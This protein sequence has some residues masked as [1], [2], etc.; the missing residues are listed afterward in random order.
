M[1]HFSDSSQSENETPT[2]E[3]IHL[4]SWLKIIYIL[5]G[6]SLYIRVL[7]Y[8]RGYGQCVTSLQNTQFPRY[9][10]NLIKR[11]KD[12]LK[13]SLMTF[14]I[15]KESWE[16]RAAELLKEPSE[17][18]IC[19]VFVN[20]CKPV[21]QCVPVNQATQSHVYELTASMHVATF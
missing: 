4:N 11:Y 15:N 10:N 19:S 8:V 21:S 16:S 18:D 12:S 17:Y 2:K 13:S 3:H 9:L 5:I 7:V 1:Y 14:D 6:F 20:V